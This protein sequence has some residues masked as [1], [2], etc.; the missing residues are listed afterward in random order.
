MYINIHTHDM[1][2][3]MYVHACIVVKLFLNL[4]KHKHLRSYIR[5]Y[6]ETCAYIHTNACM[7]IHLCAI[8]ASTFNPLSCMIFLRIENMKDCVR[9]RTRI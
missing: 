7:Y 5:T 8:L 9:T 2:M 3:L 6:V 4:C 1:C